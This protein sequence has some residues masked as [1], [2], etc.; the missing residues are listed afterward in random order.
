MRAKE[1]SLS[2]RQKVINRSSKGPSGYEELIA[3]TSPSGPQ[4]GPSRGQARIAVRDG[5]RHV[6]LLCDR[7][8]ADSSPLR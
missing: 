8:I 7:R 6:V 1:C 5:T 2:C 3:A 4:D